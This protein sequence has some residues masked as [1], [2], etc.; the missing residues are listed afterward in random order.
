VTRC[1]LDTNFVYAHLRS[2]RGATLGPVESWRARTL[3]A[4]DDGGVISALVLDEL[5]YRLILAWLRDDGDRDPLTTYQANPPKAMRTARRRLSATWQ[6]IDSLSLELQPT[7][8]AVVEKAKSLMASP[9]LPPRDAFH[10]AH[11]VEAR[12]DLIASADSDFDQVPELRR[13]VP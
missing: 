1:Y 5:A 4:M 6:A 2:Q 9:G 10:A 3:S 7:D 8:R 12:C 13:I 11:A